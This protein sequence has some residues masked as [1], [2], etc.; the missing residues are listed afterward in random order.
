[1]SQLKLEGKNKVDAT[2]VSKEWR[3][4]TRIKPTRFAR[5]LRSLARGRLMRQSL[6]AQGA[7]REVGMVDQ[8]GGWQDGAAR[9]RAAIGGGSGQRAARR[10][11]RRVA[12]RASVAWAEGGSGSGQGWRGGRGDGWALRRGGQQGEATVNGRRGRGTA[13]AR[14]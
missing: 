6:C 3:H 4:N 5:S 11:Q 9:R 1:M 13:V 12:L 14:R 7:A 2:D 8:R 10:S